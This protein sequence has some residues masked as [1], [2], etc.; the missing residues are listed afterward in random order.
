MESF[1]PR[2]GGNLSTG[3]IFLET[4]SL[5]FGWVFALCRL[6]WWYTSGGVFLCLS[7]GLLSGDIRDYFE[8]F[9]LFL[10]VQLISHEACHCR[11]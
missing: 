6:M 2:S 11:L 8:Q 4:Y 5:C 3:I 10:F 7:G 1:P 9:A